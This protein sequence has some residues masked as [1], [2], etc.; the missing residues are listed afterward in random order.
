[1][2]YLCYA[3]ALQCRITMTRPN[4]LASARRVPCLRRER[5][6]RVCGSTFPHQARPDSTPRFASSRPAAICAPPCHNFSSPA[7]T[8]TT[9]KLSLQRSYTTGKMTEFQKITREAGDGV[10]KAK[11]GDM[12]TME[13][14]GWLFDPS[15]PDNKGNQC[16]HLVRD[17]LTAR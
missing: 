12:V 6:A 8:S 17:L 1:M 9:P 16:V 10:T 13:Y 15:K 7:R 14:T 5:V 11:Q 2:G 3:L 4:L